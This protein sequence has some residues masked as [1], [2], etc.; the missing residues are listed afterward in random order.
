MLAIGPRVLAFG[1]LIMF[2]PPR[3]PRLDP[4]KDYTHMRW[5]LASP[6]TAVI[7]DSVPRVPSLES[8]LPTTCRVSLLKN[9]LRVPRLATLTHIRPDRHRV[10][11]R[12]ASAIP[13]E[14]NATGL[15]ILSK[16]R[17]VIALNDSML[18]TPP[19]LNDRSVYILP[20][21]RVVVGKPGAVEVK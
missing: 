18:L 14:S 12:V 17:S 16:D 6:G 8:T 9:V 3:I 2:V 11:P 20:V 1:L 7:S 5:P 19:E 21:H 15:A 10:A 4:L 13:F